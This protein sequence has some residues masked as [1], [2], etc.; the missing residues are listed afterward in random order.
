VRRS[1]ALGIAQHLEG[2][3]EPGR[4]FLLIAVV[5]VLTPNTVA[6]AAMSSLW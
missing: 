2:E 5:C 6:P 1:T 4:H 3:M